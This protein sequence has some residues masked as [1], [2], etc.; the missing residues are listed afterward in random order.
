MPYAL[1]MISPLPGEKEISI[2]KWAHFEQSVQDLKLTSANSQLL[3]KGVWQ[4]FLDHDIQQFHKL[5]I[6]ATKAGLEFRYVITPDQLSW[7]YSSPI[8]GGSK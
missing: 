1:F 7:I 8:K 2:S 3:A 4:L 5:I 6:D